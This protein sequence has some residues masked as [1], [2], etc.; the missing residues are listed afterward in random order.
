MNYQLL[1]RQDSH[2]RSDLEQASLLLKPKHGE[3]FEKVKS[4]LEL[5]RLCKAVDKIQANKVVIAL[6]KKLPLEIKNNLSLKYIEGD[7]VRFVYTNN[8]QD[9]YTI[10]NTY[11]GEEEVDNYMR[12]GTDITTDDELYRLVNEAIIKA[13]VK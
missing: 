13:S 7:R 10:I 8:I 11:L 9:S 4:N 2:P 12:K 6:C 3:A 5:H 1:E